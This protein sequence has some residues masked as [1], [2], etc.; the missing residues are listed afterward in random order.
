MVT[1]DELRRKVDQAEREERNREE[2]RIT[3]EA[4]SKARIAQESAQVEQ[5]RLKQVRLA[6]ERSPL[7]QELWGTPQRAYSTWK[8]R[9]RNLVAIAEDYGRVMSREAQEARRQYGDVTGQLVHWEIYRTFFLDKP[10]LRKL[11]VENVTASEFS[12]CI[13]YSDDLRDHLA[14]KKVQIND[15]DMVRNGSEESFGTLTKEDLY[16]YLLSAFPGG[17]QVIK[18]FSGWTEFS[19]LRNALRKILIPTIIADRIRTRMTEIHFA[20]NIFNELG[21]AMRGGTLPFTYQCTI[22]TG[23]WKISQHDF[24]STSQTHLRESL[25]TIQQKLK[26]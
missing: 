5:T 10:A 18:H 20:E 15:F 8:E 24:H 13:Q 12:Y 14:G 11:R 2:A 21:I 19:E 25:F 17:A 3:Q 1:F 7:E 6:E 23:T 4:Q 22:G 9:T 16:T 26:M